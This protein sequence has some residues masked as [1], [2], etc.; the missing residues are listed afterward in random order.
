MISMLAAIAHPRDHAFPFRRAHQA[1]PT[2]VANIRAETTKR[3]VEI[4]PKTIEPLD[5]SGA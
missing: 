1:T 3:I 2:G 4:I 5:M